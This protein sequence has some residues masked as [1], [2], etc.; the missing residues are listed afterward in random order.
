MGWGEEDDDWAMDAEAFMAEVLGMACPWEMEEEECI[1]GP[2]DE[3]PADQHTT[4]LPLAEPESP[5]EL[6][7]AVVRREE[8]RQIVEKRKRRRC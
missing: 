5:D 1:S 6:H 8:E 2:P 4:F 7:A 3:E